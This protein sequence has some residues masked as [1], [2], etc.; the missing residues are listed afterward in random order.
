MAVSKVLVAVIILFAVIILY[1]TLDFMFWMFKKLGFEADAK[2]FT[3][4]GSWKKK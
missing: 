2:D 3:S 4:D 1:F